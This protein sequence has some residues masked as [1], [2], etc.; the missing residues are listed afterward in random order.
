VKQGNGETVLEPARRVP[1]YGRCDVL[2]VG[3]GPA[4]FAPAVAAAPLS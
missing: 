4:G 3:G 1:V 2:V